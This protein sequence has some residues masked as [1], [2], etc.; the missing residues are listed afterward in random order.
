MKILYQKKNII[1]TVEKFKMKDIISKTTHMII[2]IKLC[3][4]N[5]T[6]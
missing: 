4:I 6:Y 5:K 3:I 1:E 2:N